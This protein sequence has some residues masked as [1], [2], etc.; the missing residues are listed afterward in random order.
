MFSFQEK[1]DAQIP[2][3]KLDYEPLINRNQSECQ[4]SLPDLLIKFFA[5]YGFK[6]KFEV[7][8]RKK[9]IV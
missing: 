2:F 8:L 1:F 4:L 7:F 9:F 3:S 6:F 5:Y